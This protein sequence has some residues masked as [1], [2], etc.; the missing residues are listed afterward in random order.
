MDLFKD[1]VCEHCGAPDWS[2]FKCCQD[3]ADRL[4][5]EREAEDT[6]EMTS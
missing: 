3:C 4:A 5:D 1:E 2:G 6:A